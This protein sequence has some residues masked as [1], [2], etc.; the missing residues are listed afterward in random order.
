MS[1]SPRPHYRLGLG[2]ILG[3]AFEDTLTRP[4]RLAQEFTFVRCHGLPRASSPHGLAAPADCRLTTPPHCVQLPLARGCYQLAPRRTYTSNP[5]PMPGTPPASL[6]TSL[7]GTVRSNFFV[8]HDHV[9][10][11]LRPCEAKL[12][13]LRCLTIIGTEGAAASLPAG[14]KRPGSTSL[15]SLPTGSHRDGRSVRGHGDQSRQSRGGRQNDWY[16]S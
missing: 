7:G 15:A 12:S 9:M 4:I 6:R 3:I 10:V 1:R 14:G 8:L 16:I 13:G 5:V 2:W 11:V